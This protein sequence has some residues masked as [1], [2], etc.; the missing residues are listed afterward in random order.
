MNNHFG[1]NTKVIPYIVSQ[2]NINAVARAHLIEMKN[3]QDVKGDCDNVLITIAIY[4]EEREC[5]CG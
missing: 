2:F 5:S 1:T 3:W 4:I